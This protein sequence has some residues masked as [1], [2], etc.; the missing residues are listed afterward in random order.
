M[1]LAAH[2][3]LGATHKA[4]IADIR[5]RYDKTRVP[6]TSHTGPMTDNEMR[7]VTLN[8]QEN[9]ERRDWEMLASGLVVEI[10]R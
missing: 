6:R 10:R 4:A 1:L 5:A 7:A 3:T 2:A 8:N 9:Y